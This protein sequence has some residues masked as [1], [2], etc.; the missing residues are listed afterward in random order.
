MILKMIN[1]KPDERINAI[2]ICKNLIMANSFYLDGIE[3][4]QLDTLV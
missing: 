1:Y 3:E 4:K 2:E